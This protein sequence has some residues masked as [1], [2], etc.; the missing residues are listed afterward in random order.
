M[1]I[2]K[3]VKR[4]ILSTNFQF[5]LNTKCSIPSVQIEEEFQRQDK[6]G[7]MS[8]FVSLNILQNNFKL[9]FGERISA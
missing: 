8:L 5:K 3:S 2:S 1:I 6:L 9:G 4:A 7:L